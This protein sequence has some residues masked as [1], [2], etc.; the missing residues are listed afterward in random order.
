MSNGELGET[1]TKPD[2]S[3]IA[4][5]LNTINEAATPG[6]EDRKEITKT[7]H[8]LEKA[9]KKYT[10]I[11]DIA[12]EESVKVT[13]NTCKLCNSQFRDEAEKMYENEVSMRK[14][15][16]WLKDDKKED[17]QYLAVQRH[18]NKHF[19][20]QENAIALS[21]FSES[22]DKWEKLNSGNEEKT[23]KRY[24][25]VLD[26]E[27]MS[28]LSSNEDVDL[29]E[30]RKNIELVSKVAS[31]IV[32]LRETIKKFEVE[33]APVKIIMQNLEKYVQITLENNTNIEVKK[34]LVEFM[35]NFMKELPKEISE[36]EVKD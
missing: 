17:L 34:A 35:Q 4:G 32:S 29:A 18:F 23:L 36:I 15:W 22:I 27:A 24:I 1:I 19:K 3:S 10:S 8:Y 14:I 33:S 9:T 11:K 12:D 5:G 7:I 28:L 31:T 26:K 21:N 25:A 2:G 30:K 16:F 13:I 20:A 6:S